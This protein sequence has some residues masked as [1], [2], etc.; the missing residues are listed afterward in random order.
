METVMLLCICLQAYIFF[1]STAKIKIDE[2]KTNFKYFPKQYSLPPRWMRKHFKL[3]KAEIPKF[4]LFRL[5][6]A[7]SYGVLAPISVIVG[8]ITQ[9][10]SH[11][12]RIMAFSSV[13]FVI[14]DSV[15]FIIMSHLFEKK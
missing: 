13:L 12:L 8:I 11:V 5:Y 4:L 2:I 14:P 15:V 1:R 6:L 9:F 7:I 10:D 3:Q